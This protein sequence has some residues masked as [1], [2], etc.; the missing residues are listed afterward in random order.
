MHPKMS[1]RY[2][3]SPINNDPSPRGATQRLLK[4]LR[5]FMTKKDVDYVKSLM[6]GMGIHCKCLVA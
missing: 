3:L 6:Y 2:F 4:P 1:L 5:Y